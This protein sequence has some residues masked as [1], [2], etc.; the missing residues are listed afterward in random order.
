MLAKLVPD[1]Q[2]TAELVQEIS[3]ASVEQNTGAEQVNTALQQLDQVI[4]QNAT[5][6]EEM[7]GT[8]EEL[9]AQAEK[10]QH[11][12]SFFK[13]EQ[14]R[15]KDNGGQTGK[16]EQTAVPRIVHLQ[17]TGEKT[18]NVFQAEAAGGSVRLDLIDKGGGG[19]RHDREFEHW[20]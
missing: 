16:K 17:K 4:Q 15:R 14:G 12:I 20:E 11:T 2:R 7:S 18:E 3:A 1:I 19:D 5:A 6:S 13:L 8:A 9:A 10:L